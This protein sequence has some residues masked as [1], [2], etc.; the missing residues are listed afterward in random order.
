MHRATAFLK[1]TYN[2]ST[3]IPNWLGL[4]S[5]PYFI[6]R[7]ELY[8]FMEEMKTQVEGVVLDVGCGQQPY[9]HLFNARSYV[10]LEIDTEQNRASK[11][12]D[13]FYSGDR[14]PLEDSSVD[15]VICNQVFE[16]VFNPLSFL[17]EVKR[18]LKP[19]GKLILTAPFMWEEHESPH[20]FA[21]YT[22]FGLDHLLRNHGFK[23]L[24]FRK[25][26]SGLKAI[27]Q[28]FLMHTINPNLHARRRLYWLFSLPLI[29]FI[30]TL[31]LFARRKNEAFYL[32]ACLLAERL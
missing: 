26:V 27:C 28:L 9:R 19:G 10:G 20:D 6:V 30:N 3:Y 12:A 14:F 1:K 2:D 15:V 24:R 11:K 13:L 7:K 23:L 25:N 22:S 8:G 21:R 5:N 32:D 4:I 18:V 16:H 31:S 17:T 29:C